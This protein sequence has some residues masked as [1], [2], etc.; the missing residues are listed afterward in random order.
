MIGFDA[1][2]ACDVFRPV[3]NRT[4]GVDGRVAIEVNPSI[5]HD[6]A[7]T[8][9]ELRALHWLI[10]RPTGMIKIPVTD[11]GLGAITGATVVDVRTIRSVASPFVS[12]VDTEM[13]RRLSKIGT[14]EAQAP[15]GGSGIANARLA[16]EHDGAV[17]ASP[18]R[19][20]L[21]AREATRQR[22][23]WASMGVT[24][25]AYPDTVYVAQAVGPTRST[26]CRRR[27]WMRSDHARI[28][29]DTIQSSYEDAAAIL[30]VLPRV[31]V[32][33]EDVMSTLTRDGVRNLSTRRMT[34]LPISQRP[35]A[36]RANAGLGC[37]RHNHR[38]QSW[39]TA[40]LL[41]DDHIGI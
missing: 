31:S 34:Y 33:D 32:D 26:R 29:T 13:D 8:V 35:C 40:R 20:Q 38:P 39:P 18:R 28:S 6:T 9:A 23:P 10:A 25:S 11:A 16:Y 24:N 37:T 41:K 22:P 7:K 27:P 17:I 1:R 30:E 3:Y 19:R 36:P 21:E 14:V 15:R 2:W 4:D 5:A 12:R